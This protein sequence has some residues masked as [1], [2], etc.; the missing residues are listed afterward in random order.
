MKTHIQIFIMIVLTASLYC[1]NSNAE[2]EQSIGSYIKGKLVNPSTVPV[3]GA[4]LVKVF[5]T[6]KRPYGS[7]ELVTII[8][9]IASE[10]ATQFP[11]KDRLQIGDVANLKGGTLGKHK[12]HQNG[13]D[14]DIVYY[15]KNGLE[16]NPDWA[17]S[18]VEKFVVKGKITE[19]FDLERNWKA[20]TKLA[21]FPQVE[22]VFVDIAIKKN[23]CK[24]YGKNADAIS[25]QALRMMR[26]AALHHDHMH[27]RITC[28]KGSPKCVPQPPVAAGNGCSSQQM[29]MDLM[30]S[31]L[32]EGEGC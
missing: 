18:Y 28:P 9:T 25:Q 8:Q 13:L 2:V 14:A 11:K 15:R 26:P 30:E 29:Q 7:Y 3:E 22:R 31:R 20:F 1:Q 24:L 23:F 27:V 17:G 32:E 5:R 4:G 12:S 16:Q 6:K 10:I 21:S 19:N